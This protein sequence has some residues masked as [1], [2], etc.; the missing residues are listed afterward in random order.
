MPE[1]HKIRH[2]AITDATRFHL[3]QRMSIP[4]LQPNGVNGPE[5]HRQAQASCGEGDGPA[6]EVACAITSLVSLLKPR[7]DYSRNVALIHLL[8][9]TALT[10]ME[11]AALQ[12]SDY[13]NEDG[14]VRAISAVRPE[15]AF[16]GR[17]RP[18]LF[19]NA[20]VRA[21]IDAYLTDR[22]RREI[23][24]SSKKGYRGLLPGSALVL[25]DYGRAF[26]VTHTTRAG[27]T[28]ECRSLTI[29]CR[30]IF[31]KKNG[32]TISARDG[33]RLLAKSLYASGADIEGIT[34][35]MGLSNKAK[36]WRLMDMDEK[37]IDHVNRIA[38]LLPMVV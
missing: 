34:A 14:T 1:D 6:S 19:S 18:L 7:L 20:R 13:L 9:A 32:M 31:T 37:G 28:R 2:Y 23:H 36:L 21:A 3:P 10:P 25:N 15:I 35:L 11:V 5:A 38:H 17:S 26:E 22:V 16:N 24:V 33:R 30:K 12:V 4:T 27:R 8:L 29:V